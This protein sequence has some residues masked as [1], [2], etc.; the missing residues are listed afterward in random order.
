MLQQISNTWRR[1][2]DFQRRGL[3]KRPLEA[4]AD[5]EPLQTCLNCGTQY[6]GR[7]C[8]GCG[9]SAKVSRLTF[10]T[11]I[12]QVVSGLTNLENGFVRTCI[13]LF[14]RPGY[15]I[16]D[17]LAG[18]RASYHKPFSMLFVLATIHVVVHYLCYH[19][20]GVQFDSMTDVGDN[21]EA[22][23][24]L[25]QVMHDVLN[26]IIA[27][28]AIL[29]LLF[30]MLLVLPNYLVFKL[31]RYGRQLNV[32]EHFYIMLFIG[33]QL[34]ILNIVELPINYLQNNQEIVGSFGSG[35]SCVLAIW[36]FRQLFGVKIR[37]SIG[38]FV[39]TSLLAIILFVTLL[40]IAALIYVNFVDP[41]IKEA[42]S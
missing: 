5:D 23:S 16:R 21:N 22:I 24:H 40:I 26:Y 1:W 3:R 11:A 4:A 25:M 37:Q 19:N 9:Q 28:Q 14:Y 39:L 20:A 33:C 13:E 41:T 34:L 30:V 6:H 42:F 2:T 12:G 36:D 38:L 18:R 31:T 17:Y 32:A 10:T 29:T 27:N 15:M 8:P 35:L 7:F